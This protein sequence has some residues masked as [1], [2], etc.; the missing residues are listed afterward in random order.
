MRLLGLHAPERTY[1]VWEPMVLLICLWDVRKIKMCEEIKMCEQKRKPPCKGVVM[2]KGFLLCAHILISAHTCG[3]V[4]MYRQ[5]Y[6]PR[7]A[8][9]C[10]IV[11][12]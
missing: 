3:V 8:G 4:G 7:G 2:E 11:P 6:P 12:D 10:A 9:Q 5:I 1:T